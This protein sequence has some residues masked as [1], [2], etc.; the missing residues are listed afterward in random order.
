MILLIHCSAVAILKPD[1]RDD[2]STAT[3]SYLE[4]YKQDMVKGGRIK[5]AFADNL[6]N[7]YNTVIS[8]D[9]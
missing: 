9:I 5:Q 7:A 3:Q 1:A 8:S 2:Q 6:N 4:Q